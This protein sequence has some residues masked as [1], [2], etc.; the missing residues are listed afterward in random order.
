[1]GRAIIMYKHISTR[2]LQAGTIA[3]FKI[4]II[5]YKILKIKIKI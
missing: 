5:Q 2:I 4:Y 3:L 1:M